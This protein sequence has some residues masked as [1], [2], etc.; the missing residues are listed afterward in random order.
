M[1]LWIGFSALQASQFAINNVSQNLANA[2]TEG[3]HRQEVGLQTSQ[4]QLIGGQIVGRGVE[5]SHVSRLRDQ[6]VESALTNSIGDLE[7]V[8]QQL[9]IESTIESILAPGERS[10]Q[11]VLTGLFDSLARLSANPSENALRDSALNQA[12]N[13]A[14]QIQEVS[15]N[16]IELRNDVRRQID[17]ELDLVNQ[18]LRSLVELQNRIEAD[19]INGSPNDLLDQRDRLVNSLAERIDIQRFE[20]RQNQ[21][22]L[23]IAGSSI[24]VG[25]VPIE[26]ESFTN[27][28][29]NVEI[30]IAG[31]DRTVSF[32]S[33]RIAALEESHNS[34][35]SEYSNKIDEFAKTL[36]RSV[37]QAHAAGVGLD[38]PFSILKSTRPVSDVNVPLTESSSFPIDNGELVL[39]ITSP[40]NEQRTS[41]ISINPDQDSLQDIANK[42]SDLDN[43]QAVVDP[44]TNQLTIVAQPGYGFDFTGNLETIPR[45]TNFSG[46]SIPKIAG[47]YQGDTNRVLTVT[48]NGAGEIGKT[49][50]LTATVT[51]PDGLVVGEINI[52]E[53]Y[54]AGT[55]IALEDGVSLTFDAGSINAADS[56]DAV[57]VA[58][59]DSAG[60]LSALGLNNFFGGTDSSDISVRRD[61]LDNSA[62]L[63]TSKN[64]EIGDTGNL[65]DIIRIRDSNIV[66]DDQLSFDDYLA[67]TNSEIGFRVQSSE[68]FQFALA[69]INFQ[70][71]T[72]RDSTSGVDINEELLN[73]TQ[74]QTSYEAAVQVVRTLEAM[75]D[76]LFQIIR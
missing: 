49:P 36:I 18:D 46:S 27:E 40:D 76:D 60:V 62:R 1:S 31:T 70:Y 38:G 71:Q 39:S 12:N 21:F 59:S 35:I 14:E 42:I 4:S 6:I 2:S 19:R 54:E 51:N 11:T 64:G 23:G 55:E 73:L 37:D 47:D 33:G 50:G 13:L 43:I 5:V 69:E 45:L 10:I 28:T 72:D 56:F 3:Y 9:N 57:L 66:G 34:L 30:R 32:Q 44:Q 17:T 52:G 74:H 58:Q 48:A 63:A 65:A 15:S 8:N 7:A 16:L 29:G 75:L 61:L 67:E 20:T 25:L 26:F 53:G 68:S 22:G 24:S 41:T